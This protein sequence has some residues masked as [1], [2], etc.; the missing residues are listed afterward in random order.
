MTDTVTP[1]QGV[2]AMKLYR[3]ARRLAT[4]RMNGSGRN[5]AG[6]RDRIRRVGSQAEGVPE[7]GTLK[8][9]GVAG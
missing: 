8:D 2:G 9:P 4:G 5:T 6:V 1:M 3:N 7:S